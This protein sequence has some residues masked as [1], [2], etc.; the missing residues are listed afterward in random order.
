MAELKPFTPRTTETIERANRY[1]AFRDS[2]AYHEVF[3]LS[4]SLVD[5]A[6][7]ALVD[8]GGWDK[9]QI[10]CLKARAQ[11]AKEHH[12]LLFATIHETINAGVSEAAQSMGIQA[13][14]EAS[15]KLRDRILSN[16]DAAESRVPGSY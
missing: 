13:T 9:D 12:A 6:T 10:A 15:D 8:Y 5:G 16:M 3:R 1:L 11:A 4:Q 2:P 7:A 14:M